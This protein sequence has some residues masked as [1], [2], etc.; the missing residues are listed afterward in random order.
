M[1][2]RVGDSVLAW[3]DMRS[4]SAGSRRAVVRRSDGAEG[5]AI[6]WMADEILVC[7]GDLIGKTQEQ[8]GALHFARDREY[9]QRDD[10]PE[11]A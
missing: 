11:P 6:A 7:E 10:P 1:A 5:V 3:E 4:G 2:N 9:L 8:I